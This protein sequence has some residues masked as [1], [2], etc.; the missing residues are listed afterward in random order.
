MFSS[1]AT[2]AIELRNPADVRNLA[3]FLG[4]NSSNAHSAL[5]VN[6]AAV[7]DHAVERRDRTKRS[8]TG[9]SAI[10]TVLEI[11]EGED[12]PCLRDGQLP[13]A[14]QRSRRIAAEAAAAKRQKL[15][16]ASPSESSISAVD[17]NKQEKADGEDK[18]VPDAPS[19][20]ADFIAL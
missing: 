18:T 13:V 1:G 4:L 20:S 8:G 15:T 12:W 19:T 7:L 10:D 6:P 11:K 2:R 17:Q 3:V 9:L 5:T 14:A 16:A